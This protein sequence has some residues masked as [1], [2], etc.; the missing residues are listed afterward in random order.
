MPGAGHVSADEGIEVLGV[1]LGISATFPHKAI[2]VFPRALWL[3][4]DFQRLSPPYSRISAAFNSCFPHL[5][6]S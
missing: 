6:Q 1:V 2:L 5:C 4:D 3:M